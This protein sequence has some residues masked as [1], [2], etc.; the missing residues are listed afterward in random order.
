MHRPAASLAVLASLALAAPAPALA[1]SDDELARELA[2]PVASLISIPFQGNWD[3]GIGP[4]DDGT[5]FRVNVQPV[6]PFRL[7]DDWN[8]ITRTIVPIV[9][10]SEVFPGA[11]TQSGIGDVLASFFFS[12]VRPTAGGLIWGAGPV[13]LVPT[14][15]DPLLTADRWAAGPTGV[16]LWQNGPWTY[17]VLGNHL[18]SVGGSSTRPDINASFVQPFASYAAGGGWSYTV[19]AEASHDWERR[20]TSIPVAALVGRIIRIGG[21][22]VQ[23][24]GGPRYYLSHF[25]NGAKGWGA[26]FVATVLLPR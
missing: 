1:Q 21:V 11:G 6:V 19:V 2:N 20:D 13:V 14:G 9:R 8:L 24:T 12:P 3:R 15:S 10:Q 18:W 7:S 4:V 25:D 26:R 16:A 23:L 5:Q 22:P 17:G